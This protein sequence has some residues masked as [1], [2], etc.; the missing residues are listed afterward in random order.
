MTRAYAITADAIAA[1]RARVDDDL[2]KIDIT[3]IVS[4]DEVELPAVGARD[5]RF[6]T[7]AVS[8]E[9]NLTHAATAD[10]VNI[11]DLR[12]GK[13]FPGTS[14]VGEVVEVGPGLRDVK[15]GDQVKKGDT[16]LLV[17]A[18][19][20]FN[21]ITAEKAGTVTD[22]LVEDGQPVE[23]GEPLVVIEQQ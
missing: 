2:S 10:T 19:K 17:E 1:E 4:M 9:H 21:P 22:I 5:V 15:V 23:Y 16:V 6:R 14:S 11:P 13:F 7:L 18:M 8:A 12:G 20:T 3:R